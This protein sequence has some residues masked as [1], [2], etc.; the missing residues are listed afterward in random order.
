MSA[1]KH[2]CPWCGEEVDLAQKHYGYNGEKIHIKCGEHYKNVNGIVP[3]LDVIK[4]K[5]KEEIAEEKLEDKV[6]E[7][8]EEKI[9]EK[10]EEN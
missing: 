10:L 9:E 4:G 5:S 6:E 2:F 7:I 8:V 1:T 3:R